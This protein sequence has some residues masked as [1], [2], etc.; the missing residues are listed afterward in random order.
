MLLNDFNVMELKEIY[1][2][3]CDYWGLQPIKFYKYDKAGLVQLIRETELI[4]EKKEYILVKFKT[5]EILSM[6]P[7]RYNFRLR[8]GKY[9]N[10]TK[11]QVFNKPITIN[12]D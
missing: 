9:Y 1:N 8:Y 7:N 5:K 11:I 6:K 2:L 12:F 10:N 3:L 4:I